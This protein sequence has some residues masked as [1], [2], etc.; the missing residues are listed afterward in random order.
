MQK[1]LS[2]T[3]T[4]RDAKRLKEARC[5]TGSRRPHVVLPFGV[6]S[7]SFVGLSGLS[8]RCATIAGVI[9]SPP[10]K[11]IGGIGWAR[12]RI[13]NPMASQVLILDSRFAALFSVRT[14]E[15]RDVERGHANLAPLSNWQQRSFL[16]NMAKKWCKDCCELWPHL[17]IG[18]SRFF[19]VRRRK[20]HLDVNLDLAMLCTTKLQSPNPVCSPLCHSAVLRS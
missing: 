16:T 7:A 2:S 11:Q 9:P 14:E 6:T 5:V 4:E 18:S 8:A 19:S 1:D 13:I 10:C 3:E 12:G 15:Q 17:L 20:K